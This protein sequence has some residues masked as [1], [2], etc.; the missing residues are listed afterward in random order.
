MQAGELRLGPDRVKKGEL[1]M[2]ADRRRSPWLIFLASLFLLAS[3]AA[4]QMAEQP[5]D[6]DQSRVG[7]L[8]DGVY[9]ND[10]YNFTWKAPVGGEPIRTATMETPAGQPQP[11]HNHMFGWTNPAEQKVLGFLAYPSAPG[12]AGE[13]LPQALVL[14]VARDRGWTVQSD[15]LGKWNGSPA[16]QVHYSTAAGLDRP[17]QAVLVRFVCIGKDVLAFQLQMPAQDYNTMADLFSVLLKQV[18]FSR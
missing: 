14:T 12:A 13:C 11:D 6:M 8:V 4:P 15:H 2:L 17:S 10:L 18:E 3:C 7:H 16:I 9:H 5:P 1:S